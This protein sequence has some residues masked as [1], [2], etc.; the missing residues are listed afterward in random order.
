MQTLIQLLLRLALL[1]ALALLMPAVLHVWPILQLAEVCLGLSLICIF[2]SP[3]YPAGWV[4]LLIP[5]D[6]VGMT[7]FKF[8]GYNDHDGCLYPLSAGIPT[9]FTFD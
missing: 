2:L 1:L 4:S 9:L 6:E 7:G 3:F 8:H 5:L